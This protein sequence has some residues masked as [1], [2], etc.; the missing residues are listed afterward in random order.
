MKLCPIGYTDHFYHRLRERFIVPNFHRTLNLIKRQFVAG[1]AQHVG[2]DRY[3][4][5]IKDIP[6]VVVLDR[7]KL[8]TVYYAG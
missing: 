3:Q 8:V 5:Q 7:G 2:G 6:A 4:V 1:A